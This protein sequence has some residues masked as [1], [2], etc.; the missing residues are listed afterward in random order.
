MAQPKTDEL[1]LGLGALDGAQGQATA[2]G[3]A[4]FLDV[5]FILDSLSILL[6]ASLFGALIGYHPA[7]KRTIDRLHEA[8]MPHV[9]VLYAVIG[10]V[11]G[12]AVREFGTLVGIVVFGIG[13]LMRFR[14]TT[15]STR[16]TVRLIVVTL[17]GLI[18][19]LGL[20]HFA[21]IIVL[22]AF[23]L[24]YLF[25]TSPPF[26]IKIEG[27]PNE[28]SIDCAEAYR[29]ILRAHNCRIIAEHHSTEKGRMDFVFRLPRRV[30]RK[31]IESELRT[32]PADLRG[33]V[34][35]EVG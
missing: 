27:V 32:I 8:D 31:Q 33:D 30:T 4:G 25:D 9:Y 10:A 24:I 17:A 26:R 5:R 13:G 3:W 14:S 2:L 16:D 7:T 6:L 35:W 12:V 20:V 15:D 28:R 19:G 1:A 29:S 11:I 22:F 34:E 18:A 23:A 21:V